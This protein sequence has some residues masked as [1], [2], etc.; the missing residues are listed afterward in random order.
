[1]STG[2]PPAFSDAVTT[3]LKSPATIHGKVM[4][5]DSCLISSKTLFLFK[6]V[7]YAN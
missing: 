4:E 6:K 3:S 7:V 5:P 2:A 1:M